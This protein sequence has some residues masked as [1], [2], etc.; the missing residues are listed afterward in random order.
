M[1]ALSDQIDSNS[2]KIIDFGLSA[3]S[4]I[5]FTNHLDDKIGTI[6]FMAPEQLSN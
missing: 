1:I 2:V 3:T 5:S 4:K 6:I